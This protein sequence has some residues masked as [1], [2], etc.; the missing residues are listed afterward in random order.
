MA[1]SLMQV[2]FQATHLL[3]HLTRAWDQIH[4][5]LDCD[6]TNPMERHP[7]SPGICRTII[8]EDI[9]DGTPHLRW[10]DLQTT[11]TVTAGFFF[12]FG[13]RYAEYSVW[14]VNLS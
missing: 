8:L 5:R 2:L 9:V 14:N 6:L 10:T 7:T 1:P 13:R 4:V 11:P 3:R 12:S